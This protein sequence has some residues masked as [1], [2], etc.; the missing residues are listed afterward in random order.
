[1]STIPVR[2]ARCS[3]PFVLASIPA[4]VGADPSAN[5]TGTQTIDCRQKPDADGDK[6]C[7]AIDGKPRKLDCSGTA[8]TDQAVAAGCV[9]ASPGQD[10]MCCPTSVHGATTSAGTTTLA[11]R[12][13]AGADTDS[14]CTNHPGK[15]RKL[16]CSTETE[17]DEALAAGC[18]RTTPTSSDVCCSTNVTGTSVAPAPNDQ[19]QATY[20]LQLEGSSDCTTLTD[21]P[22]TFGTFS[23]SAPVANGQSVNGGTA[24]VVCSVK[25]S[26]TGFAV[27][28][29]A[30]V[31][32]DSSL[33]LVGT[34]NATSPPGTL[35]G[36]F[37]FASGASFTRDGCVATYPSSGGIASGRVWVNVSCPPVAGASTI[38][39]KCSISGEARFENCT[40]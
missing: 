18:E 34:L 32:G 5:A 21:P 3:L 28:A 35:T 19:A 30:S 10:D 7:A 29:L 36:T 40:Q 14:E 6:E 4:C 20:T 39:D 38:P 12:Q 1:M 33:Q 11:C 26:G 2:L 25:T 23:P 15:P 27:S 31:S 37:I 22:L 9:R 17:T 24:S 16:D 8:Q 13:K